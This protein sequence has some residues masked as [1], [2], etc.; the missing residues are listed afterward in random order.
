MKPQFV[1]NIKITPKFYFNSV[2]LH[3]SIRKRVGQSCKV[4]FDNIEIEHTDHRDYIT[5]NIVVDTRDY[6]F[7]KELIEDVSKSIEVTKYVNLESH[8]ASYE[9]L[10]A[11]N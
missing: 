10:R 1:N 4:K 2:V 11:F 3:C 7:F 8:R 5:F 9:L 6:V